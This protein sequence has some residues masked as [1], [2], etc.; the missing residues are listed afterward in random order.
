MP[1]NTH[2]MPDGK[3]DDTKLG[4]RQAT[5]R[6]NNEHDVRCQLDLD[7]QHYG[8]R[9]DN[10]RL[11]H[12][13]G[14]RVQVDNGGNTR[15]KPRRRIGA[16][17]KLAKDSFST[18]TYDGNRQANEGRTGHNE[19]GSDVRRSHRTER[20]TGHTGDGNPSSARA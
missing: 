9:M 19:Y 17:R 15:P 7:V 16:R 2:H 6:S 5:S 4:T 8:A 13:P 18:A 10:S 3:A 1:G 14:R 20:R 12:N 11:L